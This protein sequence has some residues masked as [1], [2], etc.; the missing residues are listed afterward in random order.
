MKKPAAQPM[1]WRNR[2]GQ[3]ASSQR[4]G[5]RSGRTAA[6]KEAKV[7]TPNT[8]KPK[9]PADIGDQ[10]LKAGA[11]TASRQPAAVNGK[12]SAKAAFVTSD[13]NRMC[14][15]RSGRCRSTI[16]ARP[17]STVSGKAIQ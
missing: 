9:E 10:Y 11:W 14:Q 2:C 7:Q 4:P 15:K 13:L 5:Q 8:V 16:R 6:R 1:V 17:Q 12:P 3:R